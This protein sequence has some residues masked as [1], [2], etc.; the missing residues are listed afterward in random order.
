MEKEKNEPTIVPTAKRDKDTM[1]EIAESEKLN[2]FLM[3]R[4][5]NAKRV[6]CNGFSLA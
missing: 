5:I 2:C 6:K 1:I 3:P 4:K